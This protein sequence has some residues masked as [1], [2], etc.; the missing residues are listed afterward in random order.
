MKYLFPFPGAL[1]AL[2]GLSA[3][4][5]QVTRSSGVAQAVG[6]ADYLSGQLNNPYARSFRNT[7]E[8]FSRMVAPT[9][10]LNAYSTSPGSIAPDREQDYG[11]YTPS[12]PRQIPWESTSLVGDFY[13]N[14]DGNV[15]PVP[16]QTLANYE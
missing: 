1:F 12:L 2:S 9:G 5:A 11:L 4:T 6:N 15:I 16:V 8:G 3:R 7:E 14:P 10:T 13:F